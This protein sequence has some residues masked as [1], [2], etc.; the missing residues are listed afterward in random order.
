[1]YTPLFWIIVAILIFDYVLEQWLDRLNA[2]TMK[3]ELPTELEGIY[4]QD[5]YKRQQNYAKEKLRFSFI[6][7]TFGLVLVLAVL[8]LGGFGWLDGIVRSI[9]ESN[10]VQAL[11]FFGIVFL[12][13]DIFGIPFDVYKTFVI[14]ARYGFNKTTPSTFIFDKL[15]GYLMA[16]I[17]GG[18]LL[19]LIIFI[20]NKT[21]DLFWFITLAVLAVFSIF[22]SM[23][24]TSL[25]LPLFNKQIP[26]SEGELRQEIEKFGNQTQ[27]KI[28]NIFVMDGSRRSTKANAFFSGLGPQKRIVLFDTLINDLNVREIVAVLAHEVGHYKKKHT[29][30]GL[31]LNILSMAIMLFVLSRFL[32]NP[33]LS[34]ALGGM[35]ASFHM[36]VIAFGMLYSP[37]SLFLGIGMNL[38]SRKNEYEA[39]N[40]AKNTYDGKALISSLKKLSVKSLSNLTPHPL[41]VFFHYSHPTLLQRISNLKK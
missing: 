22:M 9:S 20:Y 34:Q 2:S 1:M 19:A 3:A 38:L 18:G 28:D 26:L 33:A 15:K 30:T 25:I 17:I 36:G 21:G 13:S 37:I 16:I 40:F 41:Y 7:E 6:T 8:F 23:F 32:D 10:V 5:E 11:L 29:L 12:A 27:F 39:D 14:E 24:Y 35:E 4:N 31:L